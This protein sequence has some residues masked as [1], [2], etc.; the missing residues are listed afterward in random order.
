MAFL[1][2]F[3]DDL[4]LHGRAT[5]DR[6]EALVTID[7]NPESLTAAITRLVKITARQPSPWIGT[8]SS[9]VSNPIGRLKANP[10]CEPLPS[11][12]C[13]KTRTQ[14]DRGHRAMTAGRN[15]L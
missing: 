15:P 14:P 3:I 8:G 2:Q 12:E 5:F 11:S 1:D 6:D 10:S 9:T 7:L 4:L 13:W